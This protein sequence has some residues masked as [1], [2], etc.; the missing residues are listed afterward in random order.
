M[1][2]VFGHRVCSVETKLG[3]N[4][5]PGIGKG[6]TLTPLQYSTV[7]SLFPTKFA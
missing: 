6:G 3:E 4:E 2:D 1:E 7:G 5:R